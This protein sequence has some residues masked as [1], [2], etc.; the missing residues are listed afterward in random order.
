[1]WSSRALYS[2]T[3]G[4]EGTDIGGEGTDIGGEETDME[5][6]KLT[7]RRRNSDKVDTKA[8][9]TLVSAT[10]DDV[11]QQSTVSSTSSSNSNNIRVTTFHSICSGALS[12]TL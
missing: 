1:M 5:E 10:C 9:G 3:L 12:S 11:K 6:K 8:E 7:W 2:L 4:G